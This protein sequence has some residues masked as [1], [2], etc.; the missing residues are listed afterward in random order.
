MCY[1]ASKFMKAHPN[2]FQTVRY[3]SAKHAPFPFP[4]ELNVWVKGCAKLVNINTNKMP[5]CYFCI[6]WIIYTQHSDI[7]VKLQAWWIFLKNYWQKILTMKKVISPAVVIFYRF[8][9]ITI[10]YKKI[11]LIRSVGGYGNARGLVAYQ[12]F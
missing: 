6:L 8:L 1:C 5:I 9:I 4:N 7:L 11:R 10:D 3:N 12:F 2:M